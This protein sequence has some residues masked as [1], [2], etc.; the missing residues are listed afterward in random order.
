MALNWKALLRGA[1]AAWQMIG[2]SLAILVILNC[3]LQTLFSLKDKI[4]ARAGWDRAPA[5]QAQSWATDYNRDS[6]VFGWQSVYSPYIEFTKAPFTSELINFNKKGE[7][8]T[9][10]SS[11]SPGAEEL[12]TFGGS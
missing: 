1:S 12:F 4:W 11:E 2:I 8:V 9:P 10:G 6:D 7:R 5:I 3:L